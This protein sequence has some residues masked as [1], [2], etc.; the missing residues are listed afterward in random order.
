MRVLGKGCKKGRGGEGKGEGEVMYLE[1]PWAKSTKV[2]NTYNRTLDSSRK[3]L[4]RW[5]PIRGIYRLGPTPEVIIEC[6]FYPKFAIIFPS[7]RIGTFLS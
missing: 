3:F 4:R 7:I 5:S 1:F 2:F 6:N